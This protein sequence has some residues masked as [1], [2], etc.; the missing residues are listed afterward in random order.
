[1]KTTHTCKSIFQRNI[2]NWIQANKG[3]I[4]KSPRRRRHKSKFSSSGST[5]SRCRRKL[6]RTYRQ[7]Q[8]YDPKECPSSN[9][10]RQGCRSAAGTTVIQECNTEVPTGDAHESGRDDGEQRNALGPRYI[11]RYLTEEEK[12][13]QKLRTRELRHKNTKPPKVWLMEM[14]GN[15]TSS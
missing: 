2:S 7:D 9:V 5:T 3:D 13:K 14:R 15:E 1:M 8:G 4:Q 11:A 6:D 12:K 10:A